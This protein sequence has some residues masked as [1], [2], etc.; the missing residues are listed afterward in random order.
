M[1]C[2]ARFPFSLL[3]KSTRDTSL[4]VPPLLSSS[5]SRRSGGGKRGRGRG[6]GKGRRAL[7]SPSLKSKNFT[8]GYVDAATP[9]WCFKLLKRAIWAYNDVR[10]SRETKGRRG[11]ENVAQGVA[12][13]Y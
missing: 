13:K 9:L 8:L 1:R 11:R 3:T 10:A 12:L 4:R 2:P 7:I 6:R 5:S